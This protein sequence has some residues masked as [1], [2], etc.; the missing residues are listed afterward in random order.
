[1]MRQMS[2]ITT[3]YAHDAYVKSTHN[4]VV[5]AT[6]AN[7]SFTAGGEAKTRAYAFSACERH[8]LI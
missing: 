4:T 1:M 8:S 2:L 5:M 6:F 7:T 3:G